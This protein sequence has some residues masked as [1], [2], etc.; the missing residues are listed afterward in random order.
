MGLPSMVTVPL[1]LCWTTLS[2][3]D[4]APPPLT[5]ALPSPLMERASSQTSTHQTF[6]GNR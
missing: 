1:P 6:L 3:A 2:E 5:S 4:W